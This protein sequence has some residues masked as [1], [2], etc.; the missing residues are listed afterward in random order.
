MKLLIDKR[1]NKR[2]CE[3]GIVHTDLGVVDLD[4]TLDGRVKSHLGH[5]F[6]VLEARVLDIYEKMPRVGSLILKKDLGAIIAN[7]GVGT[8][9]IVVDAGAGSGGTAIM[10]GWIVMPTGKVYTYEKRD[11]HAETARKNISLAG[12]GDCVEVKQQD[13]EEGIDENPNV[14][15]LDLPEPWR[16]A[17]NAHE[18]LMRGGAIAVYNPY[19]EQARKSY[20]SLKKVGFGEVRTIEILEREIEI[21]AVGTRPK[22][23]MLGHTAYLTFGRKY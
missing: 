6:R 23:R 9:D 8:G 7:T 13:I 14:I 3:G 21:R 22:T 12:L 15:I 11:K 18:V 17:E 19:L 4:K 20:L 10:M 1:G 2:L 5:E 16:I